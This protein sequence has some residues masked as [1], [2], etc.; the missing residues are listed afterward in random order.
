VTAADTPPM[1][2]VPEP[3][4]RPAPRTSPSTARP[5]WA[6]YRPKVAAHCDDCLAYLHQNGGHGPAPLKARHKRTAG[7]TTRLLCDPHAQQQREADRG[8]TP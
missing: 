7:I 2:D 8:M 5:V 1:F 6:K 3:S 4:A